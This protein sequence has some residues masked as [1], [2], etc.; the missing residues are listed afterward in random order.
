MHMKAVS[1]ML[2]VDGAFRSAPAVS[3][4]PNINKNKRKFR[5]KTEVVIVVV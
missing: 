3:N 5:S 2:L 4:R 1:S